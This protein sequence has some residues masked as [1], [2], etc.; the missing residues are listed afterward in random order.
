MKGLLDGLFPEFTQVFKNPCGHTALVVLSICPSPAAI[1]TM[2]EDV[3]MD[4]I[5]SGR[6]GRLMK[7][8]LHALH[9]VA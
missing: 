7:K 4:V 8:K 6:Q 5:R 3:F 1:A 9:Q 2:N